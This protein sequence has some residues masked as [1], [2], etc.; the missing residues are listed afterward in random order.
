MVLED[1]TDD[2]KR[3]KVRGGGRWRLR[4]WLGQGGALLY[5]KAQGPSENPRIREKN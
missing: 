5:A 4:E 2:G 3:S 1:Y